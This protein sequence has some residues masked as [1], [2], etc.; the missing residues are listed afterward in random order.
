VTSVLKGGALIHLPDMR[1]EQ[2]RAY[3]AD[4]RHF[5][6]AQRL[7]VGSVIVAP[8]VVRDTRLGR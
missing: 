1:E 5:E 3:C 8:L 2:T 7:G 6:L 4:D